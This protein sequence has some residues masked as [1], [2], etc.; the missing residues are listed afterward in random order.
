MNL[1]NLRC[2][3]HEIKSLILKYA[4][5]VD[6]QHLPAPAKKQL[7]LRIDLYDKLTALIEKMEQ[8]NKAN[9]GSGTGSFLTKAEREHLSKELDGYPMGFLQKIGY[10]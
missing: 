7:Q 8:A 6:L 10:Y 4:N 1:S 3:Q 2:K 5:A 9:T